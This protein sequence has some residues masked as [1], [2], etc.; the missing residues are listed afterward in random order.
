MIEDNNLCPG[1]LVLRIDPQPFSLYGSISQD[2][3]I[4]KDAAI[5][6]VISDPILFVCARIRGVDR[7]YGRGLADDIWADV[8][9]M[10]GP[11]SVGWYWWDGFGFSV[12]GD[13]HV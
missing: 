7:K 11:G 1:D 9:F 5:I 13:E 6:S 3:T 8:L 2:F 4:L 10:I 12:V